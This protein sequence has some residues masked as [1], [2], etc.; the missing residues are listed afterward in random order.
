MRGFSREA[1]GRLTARVHLCPR[2]AGRD[3][4]DNESSL[5]SRGLLRRRVVALL[6]TGFVAGAAA[7][8]AMTLL[9]RPANPPAVEPIEIRNPDGADERRELIERRE[10]AERRERVERRRRAERRERR[11]RREARRRARRRAAQAP[12]ATSAPAPEAAPSPEP[13]PAAPPPPAPTDGDD[14]DDGG[15]DGGGD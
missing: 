10:R 12:P 14:D 8:G 3:R 11:A 5:T 6:A 1:H 4:D 2:V 13:G 7:V 15:D 9:L